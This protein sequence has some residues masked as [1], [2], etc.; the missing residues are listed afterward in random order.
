MSRPYPTVLLTGF[1]PYGGM[2]TNPAYA[3]M[4]ALDGETIAGH[5]VIGRPL[6]VSIARIGAV[7]DDLLQG[8]HPQ[9]VISLGLAPGEPGDQA[10]TCRIEPCRF[11]SG[12]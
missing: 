4:R 5:Q 7:I 12:R 6:P 9:A 10:R 2:S 1:E 11:R 3:A 8:A